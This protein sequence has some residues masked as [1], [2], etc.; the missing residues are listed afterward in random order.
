MR[1]PYPT[2]MTSMS[3]HTKA[4]LVILFAAA[5]IR[6]VIVLNLPILFIA[7]AGHDDGLFMRLASTL[8]SGN[9]LGEFSQFT[10]MKGPGYPAFLTVTSL[11]GLPLSA[12]HAL[13]QI[14]AIAVTAWAVYRLTES[15][16]IAALTFFILTFYPV[17]FMP[18]LLRVV[19]DQIYWAQSLLIFSLFAILSFTPPRGRSAAMLVAG[20]AGLILGWAWLTREEGI[21][22]IP[23]LGLLAAGAILIHRKERNELLALARNF[24]IAAVGF[25]A[26]NAAFMTENLIA[27]GSFVGV[28]FKE[29]NFQS[30]LEA[31]DDVD[32]GPVIPYLPVPLAAR[33][34]VAKISPTFAPLS[35]AL[36]PGGASFGWSAV[37]C[38]IYKQTCGDIAGG[39]FMWALRDAAALNNFYQSPK[40]AAENFGKIANDIVAA[41]TDGRL[42]CHR[43]WVS[44]MPRVTGRQWLSIP[45]SLLAVADKVSFLNAPIPV[46]TNR[47]SVRTEEFERFW[48]FLN[49]PHVYTADQSGGETIV[50]GWYHDSQSAE[51]PVFKAYAGNGQEIPTSMTRQASPDIRQHFSDERAD[52]NRFQMSFRCPNTCTIAALMN[53]RPNLRVAVDRNQS[54]SVAS[55]SAVLFVDSVSGDGRGISFVNPGEKLAAHIRAGLVRLYRILMPLLLITGL[56]AA[57]TASWRAVSTRAFD[58]M[59]LTAL[60][61]WA[62]VSTRIVILALIDVS[63]FPAANILYS[64][65]A[66]NMAVVAAFLSIAALVVKPFPA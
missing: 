34:E 55:G 8:A 6:F 44:Y 13:F 36:A 45:H 47:S 56:I 54:M 52:N 5:L 18:E 9:W 3:K 61:A 57:A 21:W 51:W 29:H 63:S 23:G 32:V 49:Y 7:N 25:I 48:T 28:D 10:L 38:S 60:A 20:L 2:A 14:A 50:R 33:A 46:M 22:F 16:A 59:L 42:H 30:V 19:R 43:R 65:P 53:Q 24:C 26:V 41:C 37:G 11:S 15:R 58:A 1:E 31:L 40:T 39:W 35:I 17:G 64:S 27:Y 12:T 66:N 4:L 62:F